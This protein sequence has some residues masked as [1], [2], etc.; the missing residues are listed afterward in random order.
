MRRIIGLCAVL[1][2]GT[3]LGAAAAPV[4]LD[5]PVFEGGIGI[6]FY[7]ETAR[8]FEKEQ[9]GVKVHV[10][11]NPRIQDQVRVRIID[12]H[13]PDAVSAPYIQW[14]SL[15]REGKM[16]DL[17]PYLAGRNWE[18]DSA[19]GDTFLPGALDSWKIDGGVYGVPLAYSCWA[20]FYNKG[21]FL[22]HGW[23]EPRT[24]DEFFAL[25]EK[26][27][28]AG[29]APVSLPGTRWLYPDS[30]FRA[31]YHNLG[32]AAGWAAINDLSPGA[33]K[34]PKVA[35]AAGV[36][37]RITKEDVQPG[38][39]GE[40]AQGAE[41]YFLQGKAAMTASGSWFFSEMKGKIPQGLEVGTMNFPV[42]ADGLSDPTTIQSG[43]DCFFVFNTGE[44]ERQRLTMDFLRFLT[45]RSRALAFAGQNDAPVAVRGVPVSAYSPRIRPMAALIA[46]AADSFNMPQT[47]MLAPVIRQA[48][49]DETRGLMEGRVTPAE[50][51]EGLERAAAADRARALQPDRVVTKHLL[52]G[53]SL[54][55]LVAALA[56]WLL[57]TGLKPFLSRKASASQGEGFG[58][59][60]P[61]MAAGFVGPAFGLYLALVLAP[62]LLAFM[63]AFT[64]WDGIGTRTW[65]GLYN[66]RS[67]LFESDA[68]WTALGNNVYLM[69]VPALVVI[70][71]ALLFAMMIHKG[72]WGAGA[73]RVILLFPNL[74]GGIAAT[75]IWL[76]AYQPHGGL[77]NAAL[78]GTGRLLH[79]PW[80]ASFADYAWLSDGHLYAALIP[81]YIWMACG[82]NLILYLAAME[83]IDPQLYEAAEIDGAPGWMQ[84]FTITLPLIRG[85]IA[86]SVVFLVIGGLNA[87]E[88]IWLLTSQDP[89][90]SVSTLGTLLVT[91]MFKDLDI[92]RAAA[93][94]VIMFSLVLAGS[95]AVMRAF[96]G[97]NVES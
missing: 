40:T 36:L 41:L 56:A 2:I 4:E 68:L 67:L 50:F 76:S 17:R 10:Y 27:R 24:W 57:G 89:S 35:R 65:A 53:S 60:R 83:G 19:W 70:P 18:N 74:L 85:V 92:G 88:M 51:S 62:A 29:I 7:K 73:F 78:S 93:L 79:W 9:P 63:W 32:G 28:A 71:L 80:L 5:I 49:I 31:A 42:F 14:T 30:F 46:G 58:R 16:V 61:G 22:E 15:V 84:F 38:W 43:S 72:V 75:L 82:F 97:E 12:G 45:S 77:V 23:K 94:A 91:T 48:R 37:A 25:C 66:F 59:L 47:M 39:E 54:V 87:F 81:I 3:G 1:G 34:D 20:L 26:I 33:W 95:A 64:H 8:L 11:G 52:A 6:G 13:L 55:V 96:K 90:A 44:P 69:V 86:I 21:M